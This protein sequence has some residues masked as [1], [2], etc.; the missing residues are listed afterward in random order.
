MGKYKHVIITVVIAA[1]V[2]YFAVGTQTGAN[3]FGT[4][5]KAK[6]IA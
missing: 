3:L 4:G 1:A 5:T 2:V 6:K